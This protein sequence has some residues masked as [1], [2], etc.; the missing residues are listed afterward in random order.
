MRKTQ[1]PAKGA[2]ER[3]G[4]DSPDAIRGTATARVEEALRHRK[5]IVKGDFGASGQ[6]ESGGQPGHVGRGIVGEFGVGW[7]G[8][9]GGAGGVG[10]VIP[11]D[12]APGMNLQGV[13]R[14]TWKTWIRGLV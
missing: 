8:M 2:A 14:C 13:G 10:G 7:A 9:V 6:G 11:V 1:V 3:C 5:P 4:D 12:P